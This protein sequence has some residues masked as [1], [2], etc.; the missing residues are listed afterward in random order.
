MKLL[1]RLRTLLL[2]ALVIALAMLVG[3]PLGWWGDG[4]TGSGDEGGMG[5][6]MSTPGKKRHEDTASHE[7]SASHVDR[8]LGRCTAVEEALTKGQISRALG[9]LQAGDQAG[10]PAAVRERWTAARKRADAALT[11]ALGRLVRDVEAGHILAAR[12]Q[13]LGLKDPVNTVVTGRVNE[14]AKKRGWPDWPGKILAARPEAEVAADVTTAGQLLARHR[15]VRVAHRGGVVDV[16]VWQATG[17]NVTV[18]LQDEAG[19][20]FPVFDRSVVEP[21]D[22]SFLEACAQV[23][24]CHRAGEVMTAWLWLC[25]C[26]ERPEAGE[27]RQE[28]AALRQLLR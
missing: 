17:R 4:A 24:I 14:L 8:M 6:G 15:R 9:L 22:P 16:S 10:V 12:S 3:G 28:L 7:D 20:T 19:V 26:V 21:V 13:L 1:L 25:H 27:H 2:V 23:R 5:A 18:R 11:E